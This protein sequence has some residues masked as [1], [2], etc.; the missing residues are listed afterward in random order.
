MSIIYYE[1]EKTFNLSTPET[2]YVIR[3]EQGRVPAHIYYGKKLAD[4][5]GIN[6]TVDFDG[7][8]WCGV[9]DWSD[10]VLSPENMQL[11]YSFQGLDA[12]TPS[13]HANYYDGSFI[14][15]AYYSGH[16]I[17]A[18]KKPLDGL[19][20]TYVEDDGEADTLEIYLTDK[21]RGMKITLVY[22]VYNTADAITRNVIVENNGSDTI[23][24][25]SVQSLNVD[26]DNKDYDFVH[27]HGCWANERHIERTPLMMG[28]QGID[29]KR[30][31][32]SHNHSPFVALMGKNATE[33]SG[34]VYGFSLVYSGNFI[35]GA[36]V[37]YKH[38]TR[39]IMG[40][41]SHNFNWVLEPGK[42]FTTP[43]AVMVYSDGGLGKMSR[44]FHDLYRTR[45]CRG[46]YRDIERPVL[47][48]N[49]EGTYF[50]FNEE[51]I[52]NIAKA[53]KGVGVELMVLDDGWFGHRD[54]DKSSLGDWY[55]DKRKLPNGID[56]L[57]NKVVDLGMRFGLWFEPEM[58][59][60]DSDL[61]RAHPDWCLHVNGRARSLCRDQLILD[62]SRDDVCEYVINAVSSVLSSAPITYVKWDMNR[63]MSE[64]GSDLLSP[65]NQPEVAHRYILGLY[66]ILKNITESFPDVLF[67]GCSG[68]GG[69]F[70][71]GMLAYFNQYWTSDDSEA[72][73]RIY[74]QY[75]TSLVM[76]CLT[77]GA[78]VS[79]VPNHQ[80]G[81]TTP[82][83]LRG[84][85]AMTGQF[86]YELD[87]TKMSEDELE[88]IRE[89]IKF[90]KKIRETVHFGDMYRLISPFDGRTCALEYTSKD[91]NTA[92]L[93]FYTLVGHPGYDNTSVKFEGL[94]PDALYKDRESGKVYSGAVLMDAG[95]KFMTR[96]DYESRVIIFDKQ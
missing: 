86:G 19:P 95:L 22:T 89:Q 49:W 29:S 18:G 55:T 73:E 65:E 77:M 4:I 93:F 8:G 75:G 27:L 53:A 28:Y 83:K 70:D 17:Y 96:K 31:S 36:E 84:D 37:N 81:R 41:N 79:A 40:I 23:N 80:V 56:G 1:N 63:N 88:E 69:R 6:E 91:K 87:I 24:L 92:V 67:E 48:N 52:L 32:S 43:E 66:K 34:D 3:L 57:A 50:D 26:F 61:Y 5:S 16:K 13:F 20:S 64:V 68:G 11:E 46:K 90:Y 10:P 71:A 33:N 9:Y 2:S 39:V 12:R 54:D 45:L 82:L 47:L 30:G 59:S 74:I 42:S 38:M 58:V 60:P 76:P 78:H 94:E 25:K 72:V 62:L 44:T 7:T 35:A 51:K 15:E 21:L 14:T 85:V